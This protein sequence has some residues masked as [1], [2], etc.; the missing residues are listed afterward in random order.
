MSDG[1]FSRFTSPVMSSDEVVEI[2]C[3]KIREVNKKKQANKNSFE[4]KTLIF[5]T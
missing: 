2:N 1:L 5:S 3:I 4:L